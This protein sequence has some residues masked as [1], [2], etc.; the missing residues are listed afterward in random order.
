MSK[1]VWDTIGERY[2]EAGVD[3]GVLFI[4]NLGV[5]WNGLVSVDESASGGDAKPFYLD[6]VK[7]ANISAAEEYAVTIAAYSSPSEFAKCD[8]TAS[9]NYGLFVTQQPR[10]PFSFSYR[11]KKGNDTVGVDY[12]Y[13]IHLVYN[14]LAAPSTRSYGTLNATPDAQTLS[15]SVTTTPPRMTGYKPTAH[16]VIDSSSTP[17]SLLARL[18]NILYGSPTTNP[19]FPSVEELVSMFSDFVQIEMYEEQADGTSAAVEYEYIESPILPVLG[20]GASAI[21]MD[22]SGNGP[23]TLNYITGD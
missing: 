12:A 8:G 20:S 19:R 21:W 6:G 15:W 2:F 10:I 22:T 23:Y 18:E 14:A 11:T 7:Y 5:P 3:H 4:N 9:V 1:L 17:A 13:K 16:M